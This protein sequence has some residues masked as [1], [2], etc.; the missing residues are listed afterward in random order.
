MFTTHITSSEL[1]SMFNVTPSLKNVHIYIHIQFMYWV[2]QTWSSLQTETIYTVKG[3]H[4]VSCFALLI[5]I[6][7]TEM[8]A[9]N[10]GQCSTTGVPSHFLYCECGLCWYQ[11][12][13]T[14]SRGP[15]IQLTV[16]GADGQP[17][18]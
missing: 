8:C 10:Q 7:D 1:W 3:N 5:Q 12:T 16:C 18:L 15:Q 14:S 13:Y 17:G 4:H 11:H 9:S 2:M 6:A